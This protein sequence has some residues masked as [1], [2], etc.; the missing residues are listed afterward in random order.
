MH[1]SMQSPLIFL[2]KKSLIR[3]MHIHFFFFIRHAYNLS[4]SS[5][6][7][8]VDLSLLYSLRADQQKYYPMLH[9]MT[10]KDVN[11]RKEKA[12]DTVA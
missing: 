3:K 11:M 9:A 10:Q 8:L 6:K 5:L 12:E 1:Q 2:K 7:F 4:V